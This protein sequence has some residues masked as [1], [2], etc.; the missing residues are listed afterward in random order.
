MSN[1]KKALRKRLFVDP[2][3]QGA[4][5][6]RVVLYWVAC[7]ITIAL[8]LLCWDII[9]GPARVF[10]MHFDDMWFY[11]GPPAIASCLLLPLVIVDI[12]R[13]SNRFVGPLLRLR[14]SMRALAR[15]E[16]VEPIEFRGGDFWHDL[17]DEFNAVRAR[18]RQLSARNE[19]EIEDE[20]PL[21][22]GL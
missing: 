12:I 20:E 7:L 14:R 13:L 3:V 19:S 1:D 11:Y 10:Y 4:L 9:N 21:G 22:I 18:I 8:M 5:I 16:N 15:G 17:A 6:A 2:K